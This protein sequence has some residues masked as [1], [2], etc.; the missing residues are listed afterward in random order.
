MISSMLLHMSCTACSSVKSSI[1]QSTNVWSPGT[2]TG[3]SLMLAL[4][5]KKEA[6]KNH[7]PSFRAC[8]TALNLLKRGGNE[9]RPMKACMP[10]VGLAAEELT[11]A[12][13]ASSKV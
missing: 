4:K 2:S 3:A 1:R 8:L 7:I 6:C 5:F 11:L 12:G 9:H 13:L 10:Y